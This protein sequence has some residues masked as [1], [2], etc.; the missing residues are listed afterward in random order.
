MSL[1]GDVH[2]FRLNKSLIYKH[3]L[4]FAPDFWSG[5]FF[6]RFPL[7]HTEL[8]GDN[9]VRHTHVHIKVLPAIHAAYRGNISAMKS[10]ELSADLCGYTVVRQKSD[11]G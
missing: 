5:L 1:R 8:A 6:T 2:I 9:I 3:L 11:Q 7:W 10:K 4:D